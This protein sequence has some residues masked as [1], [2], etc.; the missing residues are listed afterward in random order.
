[1]NSTIDQTTINGQS[2]FLTTDVMEA[3]EGEQQASVLLADA[4]MRMD[5]LIGDYQ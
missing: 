4:L 2:N 3:E 1:M 5:G